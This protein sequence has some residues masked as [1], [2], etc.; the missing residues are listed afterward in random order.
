MLTLGWQAIDWIEW[1]LVHGP[2]DV[3]GEQIELD[4]EFAAFLL[5]AYEVDAAGTRIVRRAVLS[6]AKGRSKSG[7]AAMIACFEALGPCR[8]DHFAE[9]GEVSDWGYEYEEGEPVGKPIKFVEVLCV[10]TEEDQAGNTYGAIHYMLDPETCSEQL[11]A[12]YP[13]LDV[14][15]T[16]INLP[17][18][19]GAIEPVTS[20]PGS[21]DGGKS[22][23]IVADESHLWVLPRLKKLHGVMTRNLL[24][25]K[26]ASGWMLETTTMY[27]PGEESVAEGTHAYAQAVREGKV[28]DRSLLFDHRQADDTL[29]PA[30]PAQRMKGLKQA[31]G[32]AAAWM[33]LEAISASWDDPQVT[34]ADFRRYWL[35]QPISL[36]GTWL[37]PGAWGKCLDVRSIPD[38]ADVVLG[39]DG[40]FNNDS[41]A[42]VAVQ[43]GEKPHVTVV[44]A[45]EKL[46]TPGWQVPIGDVEEAI[47]EACR[48]WQVVEIACDPFRW[49]RT[50]QIL[51]S[52]GLPV[53]EF[54][55]SATRMTP[56]T[57][58]F[59]DMTVTEQLTHDGD[60]GLE[61]HLANAVLKDD[62]RGKRL[63]KEHRNSKRRIDLAV[64]AVMALERAC[65]H[66][67]QDTGSPGIY[68]V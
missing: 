67:T 15:L 27:A 37:P 59:Y 61:R 51:D 12:D 68:F 9:A 13:N 10:A 28:A 40:S 21:A 43:V 25:R 33:N 66:A 53:V 31:Y 26:V 62:S 44:Q 46:D 6:R 41:T 65:W 23:F 32:A 39:F 30:K 64:A 45:W 52:E 22:T 34:E 47:R 36:S 16:R 11:K 48:K 58:R 1:Y 7:F 4:D 29:D 3:Q 57:Q 2:G 38:A 24:K 55:Q 60:P 18:K 49:A 56:A 50:Y 19:R 14:G 63:S 5:K 54:P 42:L 17:G 35:N 8:F 20:A